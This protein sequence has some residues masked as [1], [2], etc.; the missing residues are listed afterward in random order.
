[1]LTAPDGREVFVVALKASFRWRNDGTLEPTPER[2]PIVAA[3]VYAGDPSKSGLV[4]AGELTLAKP[5]VDIIVVGEIVLR[6]PA[7]QVDCSLLVGSSVTKTLRVYG[8]R[9]WLPGV[10]RAVVPSG[11]K[12]F[13]R[14]PIG[15]ERSFGGTD[16]D[17]PSS[18]ERRNPVGQGVRK[19]LQ[20]LVGTPAPSFEDPRQP[21]SDAAKRTVPVGFGPVAPHWLPRGDFAGT[22]DEVW[23]RDRFPLL[24]L[25]FDARFL[26]AAPADQ[27]L[28][29][30]QP[31]DEVL[32]ANFTPAGRDSFRL[33]ELAPKLTVVESRTI[34]EVPSVVDTIVIEPALGRV[35]VV[36]RA[37]YAPRDVAALQAAFMGPLSR[38]QRRAL[39]T[40]K[41]YLRL[42]A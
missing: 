29:R 16:P 20:T 25:D 32:L 31:G 10:I 21:I 13:S 3:D 23:E 5:R 28:E 33:P 6:A 37:V 35:S 7:E 2:V 17:D 39:E 8:N 40:G 38:G 34:R 26:N 24:P 27:Q 11:P 19:K 4:A 30:Y 9:Y 18:V 15:W 22:Y 12:P 36:A 14:M 41:V 1:V 42:G